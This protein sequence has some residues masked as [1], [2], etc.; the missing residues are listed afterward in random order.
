MGWNSTLVN[1]FVCPSRVAS[2]FLVSR[3]NTIIFESTPP[4][5]IKLFSA[6]I[7]TQLIPGGFV[8]CIVFEVR[9]TYSL[10]SSSL[11]RVGEMTRFFLCFDNLFFG[12]ISEKENQ[13]WHYSI[14]LASIFSLI[15]S[16]S[17]DWEEEVDSTS[18]GSTF[19]CFCD[20]LLT[21][22]VPCKLFKALKNWKKKKEIILIEKILNMI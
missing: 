5:K 17:S 22:E 11:D 14:E 19:D 1:A 10:I 6:L 20:W 4:V 16:G 12:K 21:W 7:S 3:L 18:I 13:E 15:S 9:T 8:L 2:A